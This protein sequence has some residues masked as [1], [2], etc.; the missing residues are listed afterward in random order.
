VAEY[1]LDKPPHYSLLPAGTQWLNWG[2][3]CL[4]FPDGDV[5]SP[6]EGALPQRGIMD[7]HMQEFALDDVGRIGF[8]YYDAPGDTGAEFV[9]VWVHPSGRWCGIVFLDHW[10]C[11]DVREATVVVGPEMEGPW[12]GSPDPAGVRTWAG[13][14]PLAADARL[15]R[16]H[17][18]ST[19]RHLPRTLLRSERPREFATQEIVLFC[20]DGAREGARRGET[21][22]VVFEED[23][24]RF[25]ATPESK[26]SRQRGTS[27]PPSDLLYT[28]EAV[29]LGWTG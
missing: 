6:F 15:R 21:V 29:L 23:R 24:Q 20:R 1:A 10:Y 17:L 11:D 22:R 13:D 2:R 18:M 14:R 9:I 12:R 19:P 27:A 26:R 3:W 16:V 28:S 7:R 5:R 8:T 25:A 4:E